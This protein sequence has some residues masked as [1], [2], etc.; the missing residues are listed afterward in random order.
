MNG[1]QRAIGAAVALDLAL[2]EGRHRWHPVALV[3]RALDLALAPWRTS[4][5]RAQLLGGAGAVAAVAAGSAALAW[6]VERGASR[7]GPVGWVGLAV[8]LKPAFALRQLLEEALAVADCLEAGRLE[9]ARRGLRALVSRPVAGLP[10][11]LVA[12]AAIESLAEN[13]GDS[14]AAPLLAFALSGLPGAAVYRVVNTAD[15]MFGYH[16][17]LE[18][19]GRA[20]ARADD[21]LSWLPSRLSALALA[22]VAGPAAG[23]RALRLARLD[24]PSTA[25]P[26]A[27]RPMASAPGIK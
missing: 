7:A 27:G 14:V 12:S 25:S 23:R 10:P 15:A 16:G 26:N 24:G 2:G 9:E 11:E 6:A 3:G 5:P 1:R 8:A 13:L 17:E 21:V 4:G 18:W 20:A 19:L 22:L